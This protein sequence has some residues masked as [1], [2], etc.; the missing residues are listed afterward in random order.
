MRTLFNTLSMSMLVASLCVSAFSQKVTVGY[1]KSVDFGGFKTYT[2]SN[3]SMPVTRPLLYFTV[4]GSVDYEL[5][6]KGLAKVEK[7][8]DLILVPQG[9]MEFGMNQA[10]GTPITSNLTGP[11][12]SF[13]A[14]MWTGAGGPSNLTAPYVPEGTLT[15]T[16]VDR[17]S[18]KVIWMGTVK[19]KLDVENKKK[20]LE[21]VDKAIVKLFKQYPP[22][23]K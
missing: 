11:P 13:N 14:T 4:I 8:G 9:G 19:E 6:S 1:D 15:I 3:P 21:R 7:D 16:F 2:W 23:K 12:P 18:N 10:A 5:K 22:G 20:S 17:N